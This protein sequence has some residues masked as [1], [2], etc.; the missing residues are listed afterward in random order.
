MSRKE[1]VAVAVALV[2]VGVFFT[3][4]QNLVSFISGQF[5]GASG[6]NNTA[7]VS[8]ANQQNQNT[9]NTMN[10]ND[11]SFSSSVTGLE[12]K[13][14]VVGTGA[15]ATAGKTVTVN[16]S[17]AFTDG[18]VFDSSYSRGVP[19]K[20]VL[21]LGQVI[22]GWD[23]GVA[24]MKVGGKRHL[25]IPGSLAYGPNGIP[26]AIPPNATL[27]FDVELLKVE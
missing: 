8:G 23:Q 2:V 24:G 12:V 18:K 11:T 17:G 7:N 22:P 21:G 14:A 1:W 27:V 20:F 6:S 3:T 4:G 15:V 19:F 16:Y 25:V 10:P 5:G 9:Q 26:G 13:D